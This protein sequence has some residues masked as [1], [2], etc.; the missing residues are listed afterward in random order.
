MGTLM[1]LESFVFA[2]PWI[3]TAL[4]SLPVLWW[5]LRLTP[6]APLRLRFPAVRLLFGLSSKEET[7]DASPLWLIILRLLAA[8]LLII[9]LAHPL[10][11]PGAPL[12]G[13]GPLVL[14]I[15]DG[16]AAAAD[17][18]SR[19]DALSRAIDQADRDDRS[20]VVLTTAPNERGRS[21]TYSGLLRPAQ[22]RSMVAAIEPKPW[23]TE[24]MSGLDA[25]GGTNF[26]GK[27]AILWL[28]D[29]L[30]GGDGEAF[31]GR[32][33]ELGNVTVLTPDTLPRIV[34]P[35]EIGESQFAVT[36]RRASAA[37]EEQA[38]VRAKGG[39]G[40]LIDQKLATFKT[41]A[42]TASLTIDVPLELRNAI[43]RLEIEGDTTAASIALLDGRWRRRPVGLISETPLDTGPTLLSELFYI[44][45]ALR[46]FS[47]LRRGPVE[48][49]LADP[50]AVIVVP[51]SAPLETAERERLTA[52]ARKGGLLL[53]F[54]GPRLAQ[55]PDDQLV[56][57]PLRRGGRTLGGAMLWTQPARLA[58]FN[59][60]SPFFGLSLPND[61]T[62]SRQ[63]LAEPSP[64]L[65]EKSWARLTDGTP[66][67]TA[68]Q[69]GDGWIVL[70]HTTSNATWS[71]LALSGLFVEM[72]KR[73][74]TTSRGVTGTGQGDR[75]LPPVTLLNGFG[76]PVEPGA[77]TQ[78]IDASDFP[79]AIVKA[80]TPPGIYGDASD[81]RALNL[82]PQIGD[83]QALKGLPQGIERK[84]YAPT[85][86]VD[87]KPW[88]LTT[89][90]LLFMAD[91]LA[92]LILRGLMPG[93][94]PGIAA[95]LFA[96]LIIFSDTA[97]VWAQKANDDF[98]L[99]AA[100]ETRLAYVVTGDPN[101]DDT[102]LRGLTGLSRMLNGRTAIE[103]A[104]PIGIDIEHDPLTLFPLLY[105]PIT[106]TQ[107][108]ISE[109]TIGR[110]NRFMSTGGTILFDLLDG[111][112]GENSGILR[113]LTRGLDIPP[114]AP[115]PPDHVLT[116]AFYLM[117]AF[118]GRWADGRLWVERPGE[119]VNDG[120]SS[121]IIGSNN[122]AAAWAIDAQ[123]RH[124]FP[125]VPGGERQREMAY[126]FGVNLVM[127][128][129]TGNYK[130]DQ[131]HVPSILERLG[132]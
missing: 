55:N 129:L 17:W 38:L 71:N 1:G 128:T 89:A 21:A 99:K 68:N 22:A 43:S 65:G 12:S 115:V 95:M 103:A 84:S 47:E 30:D 126:R 54:A 62:I 13:N 108:Q 6:P 67:V 130:S 8:T 72:L 11:S 3:L 39:D 119:R 25:L 109:A 2:S 53:R 34:S 104:T 44:E 70:I 41:G 105:W 120:V 92:A 85:A 73:I 60:Q 124:L 76:H 23:P 77:S 69:M 97:P 116:K 26:T 111:G 64:D 18:T 75:P 127:Y 132:N 87:L 31:A 90:L 16:W 45:R 27:P 42:A 102:S 121:V 48:K 101:V 112:S 94:R 113:R 123:G 118:P 61:V 7:P 125:A 98:A 86:E 79:A 40:R 93:L 96:A 88:F 107:P 80:S 57:V 78:A 10:F 29:G 35:P 83:F 37:G 52:W 33:S 36:L 81:R 4:L 15:D 24:R 110:L 19:Q 106:D 9:A 59:R 91:A 49:L 122:W 32:L 114:L 46:P 58:P 82:G 51:D 56:S 28:S 74:V 117:Q 20:I 50:L 100:L 5:L 63:V 131:V 14:V 66:L